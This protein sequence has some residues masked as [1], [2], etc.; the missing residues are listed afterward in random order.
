MTLLQRLGFRR[1]T[2]YVSERW[3]KEHCAGEREEFIGVTWRWP[4]QKRINEL[5]RWNRT[6][7]RQR[8]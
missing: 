6:K 2:E 7:L 3:L 1:Q 4:I 8:A 5:G